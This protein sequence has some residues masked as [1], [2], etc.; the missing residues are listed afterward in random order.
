MSASPH[1]EA[2][3]AGDV[4]GQ[5]A[6]GSYIIQ[7]NV[8]HGGVVYVAGPGETPTPR[9]RAM[10]VRL[11]GRV[12]AIVGR[13]SE[14]ASITEVLGPSAPVELYGP[15]G[16]GKTALLKVVI[17]SH[18]EQAPHASVVYHSAIGE[19]PSDTLQFLFDAFYECGVPFKPTDA[20]LRIALAVVHGLVVIDDV[21]WK[22]N[23]LSTV[24]DAV[25][26]VTAL[27]ASMQQCLWGTGVAIAVAGLSGDDAVALLSRDMGRPLV[28][29]EGVAAQSMTAAIGGEPLAVLQLASLVR[30]VGR[31]LSRIADEL[32]STAPLGQEI[33]RRLSSSLSDDERLVLMA[34]EAAGGAALTAKHLATLTGLPAVQPCIDALIALRLAQQHSP[35]Y[36][37][38]RAQSP[39]AAA[40]RA[41]AACLEEC[42]DDVEQVVELSGAIVLSIRSAIASGNWEGVLSLSRRAESGLIV[43]RRWGAWAEVL[44]AQLSAAKALGRPHAEAWA[45]HQLGTRALCLEDLNGADSLLA[46][47]LEMRRAL[48]DEPGAAATAHNLE[49]VRG[50]ALPSPPEA[51]AS[52][53]SEL[54][55]RRGA[56]LLAIAVGIALLL[57]L[58]WVVFHST[59][60]PTAALSR[61]SLVAVDAGVDFGSADVGAPGSVRSVRFSNGGDQSLRDLRLVVDGAQGAEFAIGTSTCEGVVPAR[62][63]CSVEIAFRPGGVGVRQAVLRDTG[64]LRLAVQL[65]GRGVDQVAPA[66]LARADPARLDFAETPLLS[67]SAAQAVQIANLGVTP[68]LVNAVSVDGDDQA[69]FIVADECTGRAVPPGGTCTVQ[70]VFSAG[71]P[72]PRRARL[73]IGIAG[74]A[75][76]VTE[77]TGDGMTESVVPE[78]PLPPLRPPVESSLP[79]SRQ[80]PTLVDIEPEPVTLDV[81]ADDP[82]GVIVSSISLVAEPTIL[83]FGG[84]AVGSTSEPRTFRV[85]SPEMLDA[86]LSSVRL[87]GEHAGDFA[88]VADDCGVAGV[89]PPDG[90]AVAVTFAPRSTGP[91]TASVEVSLVGDRSTSIAVIG[92]GLRPIDPDPGMLLAVQES[93]D[94]G[95]VRIGSA[96]STATLIV[97]N[98]GGSP[99][100][101]PGILMDGPGDYEVDD[102]TCIPAALSSQTEATVVLPGGICVITVRFT[103]L[104]PGPRMGNLVLAPVESTPLSVALHGIGERPRERGGTDTNTLTSASSGSTGGSGGVVDPGNLETGEIHGR[105][106]HVG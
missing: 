56:M 38:T 47:A 89:V 44:E 30:T 18:S 92:E 22:R 51:L 50:P 87:S 68:F 106:T 43:G 85:I 33:A 90:C 9:L 77:L 58:A 46:Q 15:A 66:P 62:A 28:D 73:V 60:A 96:P 93:L 1:I 63:S 48:G 103:P 84:H 81:G 95:T 45:L 20:Q 76:P 37:A 54:P 64:D 7:N 82:G 29:E 35:R 71:A 27:C 105:P 19:P 59:N 2:R 61:A 11:C 12:P 31:S 102:F 32:P 21:A 100:A 16:I 13:R 49:L 65:S 55:F 23:E 79:P 39:G 72:G 98:S 36:S 24:L 83:D 26:L 88:I 3:I 86:E 57:G 52:A 40:L 4:S 69:D 5:V 104:E 75:P 8:D 17:G 74:A 6:V 99:L 94:F 70:V 41:T 34:L 91:L 97:I 25:P 80:P 42:G 67:P 10:P 53:P 14:L 78:E 101:I